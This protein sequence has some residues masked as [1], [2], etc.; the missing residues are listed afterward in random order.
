M[1]KYSES[2]IAYAWWRM[3]AILISIGAMMF[4]VSSWV[5]TGDVH[6]RDEACRQ[7]LECIDL[8]VEREHCDVLYP[9][10]A[11]RE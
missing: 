5:K 4:G 10:C 1:S 9:A 6:R 3:A 7:V 2:F 11:E 8:G